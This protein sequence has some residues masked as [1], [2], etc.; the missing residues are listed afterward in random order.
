MLNFILAR[1]G[2]SSTY[3]NL[4]VLLTAVGVGVAPEL[5]S[6]IISIGLGTAGV[7]GAVLPDKLKD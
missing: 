4:F 2:E 6:A 3:R 1:L 5:Q 7:L